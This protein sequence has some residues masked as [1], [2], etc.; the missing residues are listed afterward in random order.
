MHNLI[1]IWWQKN[2]I[3]TPRRTASTTYRSFTLE[4]H[5]VYIVWKKCAAGKAH[6]Y[7]HRIHFY[8]DLVLVLL[9]IFMVWIMCICGS[10]LLKPRIYIDQSSL[11]FLCCRLG[12]KYGEKAVRR[13]V[14]FC[15]VKT[16]TGSRFA[17]SL[18]NSAISSPLATEFKRTTTTNRDKKG[19]VSNYLL[20]SFLYVFVT[21]EPFLFLCRS[22]HQSQTQGPPWMPDPWAVTRTWQWRILRL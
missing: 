7:P 8:A 18:H 20:M 13:Q 21:V 17:Q 1:S 9:Q 15:L 10:F 4:F 14:V 6:V 3:T 11:L 16:W 2:G 22:F 19:R 12:W 5:D